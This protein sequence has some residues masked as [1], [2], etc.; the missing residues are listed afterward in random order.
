[1]G[2]EI[3]A[4]KYKGTLVYL[5]DKDK[6]KETHFVPNSS[7]ELYMKYRKTTPTICKIYDKVQD[8]RDAA[9]GII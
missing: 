6:N 5:I 9:E 4:Y 3:I 7:W 1:M 8:A 2:S